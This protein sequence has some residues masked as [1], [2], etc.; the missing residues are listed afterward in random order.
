MIT[1]VDTNILLDILTD[2]PSYRDRSEAALTAS[3]T[4]GP[5]VF[6]EAVYA[7][8][9][10]N[11]DSTGGA[12]RFLDEL[13]LSF[14]GSSFDALQSAGMAWV[15]YSRSRGRTWSCSSCG[16]RQLVTCNRCGS[17]QVMRQHLLGDFLVGAHALH[18]A[19][20]LLTRDRG[21]FRRYFP[22]LTIMSP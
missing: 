5:T 17:P 22:N 7:E 13:G 21:Y 2:D 11:L 12:G 16:N 14:V 6:S 4:A 9:S 18:H 10:G 15:E 1:A 19:N 3:L 20:R 8:L